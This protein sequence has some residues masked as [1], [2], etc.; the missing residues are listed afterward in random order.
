VPGLLLEPVWRRLADFQKKPLQSRSPALKSFVYRFN[1]ASFDILMTTPARTNRLFT[2]PEP[3][4][5]DHA[6]DPWLAVVADKLKGLHFGVVQI[7]VHDSKVV[8]IERTERTRFEIPQS[9][10]A[11]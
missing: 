9:L 4:S 7:V 6:P 3:A 10:S 8:Q 2:A 1:I 11:R 5:S